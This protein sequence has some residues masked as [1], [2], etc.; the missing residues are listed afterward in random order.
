M[1]E[2][3]KN[4]VSPF[5]EVLLTGDFFLVGVFVEEFRTLEGVDFVWGIPTVQG[6]NIKGFCNKQN[7]KKTAKKK[8]KE[9][10]R[11]KETEKSHNNPIKNKDF[12]ESCILNEI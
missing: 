8:K 5:G 11:K 6:N 1:L 3:R 4:P 12:K 10:K 7:E 2:K 9:K